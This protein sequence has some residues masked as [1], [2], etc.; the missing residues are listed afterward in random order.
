MSL[1]SEGNPKTRKEQLFNFWV[2][3]SKVEIDNISRSRAG[4]EILQTP[5]DRG[6]KDL[7]TTI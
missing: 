2:C 7:Q 5:L 3:D 4:L 1:H 6:Q